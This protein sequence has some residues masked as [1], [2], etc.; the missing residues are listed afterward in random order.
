MRLLDLVPTQQ[1]WDV[2]D[3]SKLTVYMSCPRKFFYE[4]ILHWRPDYP[5]NHLHFGSCWHLAC[6]HLL[7]GSYSRES[8]EEAK[9]LFYNAYRQVFDSESDGMYAPKDPSN[10]LATL[11]TYWKR[12]ANDAREYRV[13]QTEVGGTV[14]IAPEMPM[15]YK[16]DAMLERYDDS[17][18]I[19]LDHKT[20]QRRM[21]NWNEQW[22]LS[23]QML[24]YLHVLYCLFGADDAVGGIRVRCTFFYKGR[25]SEYDESRIEKS[26]N[27]MQAFI[28]NLQSWYGN[29]KYDM[30]FLLQSDSTEH[31]TML[32]FPMNP[33]AC[34]NYGRQ[35]S[36][37]DFCGAWANPL[38]RCE[39]VPLGFVKEVWNP[40]LDAGAKSFIDLTKEQQNV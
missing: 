33:Q 37:F 4:H 20:S 9:Y 18:V 2:I 40:T 39:S 35:C 15:F 16:I 7:N 13:L 24:T 38:T 31:Q 29:L 17:K 8:L 26:L 21:S 22:L 19:C 34:F 30:N 12:F 6:E 1:A 3:P 36:Y 28:D 27:Q 14:L 11:E 10:A 32:S 5:N 23:V 25:P